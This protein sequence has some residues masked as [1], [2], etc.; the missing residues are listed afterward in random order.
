MV[1][2]IIGTYDILKSFFFCR[3]LA[4]EGNK[5]DDGNDYVCQLS[6]YVHLKNA[7]PNNNQY[8]YIHLKK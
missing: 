5:F 3:M 6:Y 7:T 8:W 1:L 2:S 4:F